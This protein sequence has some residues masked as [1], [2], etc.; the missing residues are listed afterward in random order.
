MRRVAKTIV[1]AA[2][3]AGLAWGGTDVA[4]GHMGGGGYAG[5]GVVVTVPPLDPA[6]DDHAEG[7]PIG[8]YC[9][10]PKRNCLL[11]NTGYAGTPCSCRDHG[12]RSHGHIVAQ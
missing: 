10:T 8:S 2:F 12:R 9:A 4:T 6:S 5:P 7:S 3:V 1:A 11:H